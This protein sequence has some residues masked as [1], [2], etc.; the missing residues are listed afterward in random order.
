MLESPI[1]PSAS[2]DR[3]LEESF[4]LHEPGE[5]TL[6]VQHR[7]GGGQSL[8]YVH[9]STFPAALSINYRIEGRSWADDL[10][11]RGFD[12]WSFDLPG[13]GGSDRPALMQRTHVARSEA[14]GRAVEAAGQI[15]RVV[16]HMREQATGARISIIAHSW[17]SIPA[18]LFAGRHAGWVD[19]LVLFGPIAQRDGGASAVG[20]VPPAILVSAV[21]QWN[22]F[23]SRVPSD[24][25]LPICKD[26]FDIWADAYLASDPTSN[27]RTPPSARV[28]SGPD[29]D[30]ED[31]WSGHFPYDLSTV[32]APTLIVRGEWDNITLDADAA[33]L[34]ESM[35]NVS[36]GARD[37]KLKR[38]AH[39]MH[40]EDNRQALFDA[41]GEFLSETA[42]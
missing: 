9:G 28:P 11:D 33:W 40:L 15:E 16:R 35:C 13:Y 17:G 7:P 30:F 26:R 41:V 39:R 27:E 21:D 19:R 18:G 25:P 42:G 1:T 12:V 37:L 10:H 2:D 24:S 36:D 38:G 31:A 14:P 3:P 4:L 6:C 20:R 5:P 8:L 34:V 32:R 22:S 29:L 23:Q